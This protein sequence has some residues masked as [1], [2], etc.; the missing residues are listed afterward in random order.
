MIYAQPV[1]SKLPWFV[2]DH[3]PEEMTVDRKNG[4]DISQRYYIVKYKEWLP[5]QQKP[6]CEILECIGEAGNLDAESMRLLRTFDICTDPYEEEDGEP[7]D[8]V[9]ESLKIFT[10]DI[11]SKTRE[12]KIPEAEINKREDLRNMRIFTIDPITAR[13]LDDALSICQI[14]EH[15]FEV[16]VHI[17]DVSYFV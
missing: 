17:A 15:I 2:L 8:H 4:R 11:D 13:D 10:K 7:T 1:N 16:G 3:E 6:V 14:S 9:H 12:W 5:H